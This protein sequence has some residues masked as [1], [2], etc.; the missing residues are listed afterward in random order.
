MAIRYS[1]ARSEA[2]SSKPPKPARGRQQ[3]LLHYF[4]GVVERPEDSVAV[5][6]ELPPVGLDQLPER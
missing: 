2:R 6:V 3:R 5:Q 4:L 1:Q